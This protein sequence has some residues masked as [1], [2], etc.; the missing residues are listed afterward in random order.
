MNKTKHVSLIG[1]GELLSGTE[2]ADTIY[3]HITPHT[4]TGGTLTSVDVWN[5]KRFITTQKAIKIVHIGNH[6]N[7]R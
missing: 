6:A 1:C 7:Y 4:I 3:V 5:G 2:T